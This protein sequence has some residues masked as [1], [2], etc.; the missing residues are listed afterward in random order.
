MRLIDWN[1]Q[2]GR[3]ADGVV[4][5][6]RT[7]AAAR[8]LGDFDVLCLQE[9]TRGFGVLPGQPG[10]DQFTELAA[11]LPGYMIFEAIGADLPPLEPGA[12][13][14]QF[15]N[16]IATRLP[17]GRMLRQLLPWPADADGPSM[18]RVALDIELTTPSGA[19]RIVTTH[20]E[21]YSARQ[22]L[23]QV[24]ALR[25]RHREACAHADQPSPAENATGPFTATSQAR[26]SIICGDFNSAFGSDAYQR[27]LEPIADAP[28]FVDA[29]VARHPGHTPPPT[30]GVYD[31]VQWSEGPLACDFVFVTDTLL[32]RVTRCEID[33]DVRASDHQPVVLELEVS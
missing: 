8:R 28:S 18:P 33:G 5:L 26:D 25:A 16:A 4:D 21:Y 1:V 12:S 19:L 17:V 6:A 7:I 13:R 29:W 10:P 31:T 15:G 30:A 32:P 20:L 23:A 24:D 11:L 9:V 27:L 2:W 14:R 22:R 3:D